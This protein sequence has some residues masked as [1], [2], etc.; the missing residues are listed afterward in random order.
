[1]VHS[2]VFFGHYKMFYCCWTREAS[3]AGLDE[4]RGE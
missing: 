1:M 3:E 2:L 4:M